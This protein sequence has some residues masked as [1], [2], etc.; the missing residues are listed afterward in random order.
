MSE[1]RELATIFAYNEDERI[2]VWPD[3][4]QSTD[5]NIGSFERPLRSLEEGKLRV[6]SGCILIYIPPKR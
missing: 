2:W 6:S 5:A 1:I 3:H 4:P